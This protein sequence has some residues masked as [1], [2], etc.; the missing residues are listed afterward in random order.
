MKIP[1]YLINYENDDAF[2]F[3]EEGQNQELELFPS[4]NIPEDLDMDPVIDYP[5]CFSKGVEPHIEF[6]LFNKLWA[7][8][9]GEW[10]PIDV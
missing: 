2:A 7:N 9:D 3:V 1:L 5:R 4:G 6:K 8:Q 10:I